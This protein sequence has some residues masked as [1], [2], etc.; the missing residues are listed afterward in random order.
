MRNMTKIKRKFIGYLSEK[1][2]DFEE[3]IEKFM[4]ENNLKK[5]PK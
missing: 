3:K 4:F 1:D 5:L 2:K